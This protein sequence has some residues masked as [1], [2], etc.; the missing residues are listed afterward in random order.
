MITVEYLTQRRKDAKDAEMINETV[1]SCHG[2]KII[3]RNIRQLSIEK[4]VDKN[5]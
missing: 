2:L 5:E 4:A 3:A 1:T